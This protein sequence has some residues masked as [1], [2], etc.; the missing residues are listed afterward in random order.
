MTEWEK[1]QS[2][3]PHVYND[4]MGKMHKEAKKLYQEYNKTTDEDE[5]HREEILSKLLKKKGKNVWIEPT[6]HCEF[7]SN[8]TI[9]N[10]VFINCNCILM[11]NTEI[12][13][14][15]NVLFGPNVCLYTANHAFDPV[16]RA[17]AICLNKPIHIGNRVWLSGDVKV[18]GGVK[19]GD[20]SIIGAGSVVIHDIPSGV[21]AAG[22][23]CRVIREITEKD[24]T[25]C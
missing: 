24:K 2:G 7:G 9:G 22:N 19:I 5:V 16:E 8:I 20:D 6:L 14:G 12:V 13:M 17:N 10:D 21:I 1:S 4:E 15:D 23:P 3:K 11:D 25:G 18:V